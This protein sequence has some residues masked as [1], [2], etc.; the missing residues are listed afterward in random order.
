MYKNVGSV[1]KIFV[2]IHTSGIQNGLYIVEN[3]FFLCVKW[4]YFNTK[5]IVF[6]KSFCLILEQNDQVSITHTHFPVECN[7]I[8]N[9]Y[10]PLGYKVW[11]GGP[12]I[13][14]IFRKWGKWT[15]GPSFNPLGCV[16]KV[17]GKSKSKFQ[18]AHSKN[19]SAHECCIEYYAINVIPKQ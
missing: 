10:Y 17:Y 19:N 14:Q 12:V 4:I 11:G 7:V 15:N 8:H 1:R 18:A 13:P 3:T 5:K 16:V 2:G 9:T 6:L